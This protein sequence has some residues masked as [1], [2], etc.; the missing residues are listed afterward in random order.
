MLHARRWGAG[1]AVLL[2]VAVGAATCDSHLGERSALR[3]TRREWVPS[4]PCA[5]VWSPRWSRSNQ[6]PLGPSPR[7]YEDKCLPDPLAAH[8]AYGS[9][10]VR[11]DARL[12]SGAVWK[13]AERDGSP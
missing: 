13:I 4:R 11:A 2:A 1:T 8:R 10:I 3:T 9:V 7:L 6:E 12:C 5:T